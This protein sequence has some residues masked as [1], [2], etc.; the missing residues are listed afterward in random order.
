MADNNIRELQT[1]FQSGSAQESYDAIIE[2]LELSGVDKEYASNFVEANYQFLSPELNAYGFVLDNPFISFI[3]RVYEGRNKISKYLLIPENWSIIHN[4]VVKDIITVEQLKGSEH[5]EDAPKL[6]FNSSFY[7]RIKQVDKLWVLKLWDWCATSGPDNQILNEAVRLYVKGIK[8]DL[9]KLW[10]DYNKKEFKISF[11]EFVLNNVNKNSKLDNSLYIVERLRR[12]LLYTNDITEVAK[13]FKNI[14]DTLNT[15]KDILENKSLI[16]KFN[17][18]IDK[19]SSNSINFIDTPLVDANDMSA[20]LRNCSENVKLSS[21]NDI[22][23]QYQ[24]Q[25]GQYKNNENIWKDQRNI[26]NNMSFNE[27]NDILKKYGID[28]FILKKLSKDA[29]FNANKIGQAVAKYLRDRK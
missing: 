16:D 5:E 23:G 1:Q 29:S 17:D 12:A 10:E 19:L 7:E 2:L 24:K 18:Y 11:Q 9:Y 6:L 14:L 27:A 13:E 21:R 20:S 26:T 15:E 4:A 8:I 28:T 3:S 25:E 22:S